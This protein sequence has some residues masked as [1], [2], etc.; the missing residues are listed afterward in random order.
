M[1]LSKSQYMRGLQCSKALWLFKYRPELAAEPDAHRQHLFDTG[2]RV[3][4]LAQQLFPGGVEVAYR[5]GDYP[6]MI[7]E[8]ARSIRQGDVVYEGSFLTD[9][10]FVRA[11]ILVRH[12][13]AWD[14]YEVK[15]TSSTK[16]VHKPDVA[17]QWYVIGRHLPLGRAY[18]VHLNNGYVRD[19]ALDV[20][21]LFTIDEVTEA[22]EDGQAA[23]ER[24]LR[25]LETVL[26]GA[27]P[28][29]PIGTQCNNP[30][31]CDFRAYCW[32]DVPFPSVLDLRK[33][34]GNRKF[35]YYHRGIVTYEDARKHIDLNAV[36]SLQVNTA[37]DRAVHVD[38]GAIGDFLGDV[39]YPV[40][41]LDFETFQ[42]AIPR[43]DGQRP[44]Q[45]VPFQY[46]L[47]VVHE[48][49]ELEHREFLAD[50]NED[51][52]HELARRLLEDL[53]G[54]GTIF[55][56]H[57]QFELDVIRDLAR[58]CAEYDAR[59]LALTRRFKDLEVPFDKLMY[60][61]PDFNG[62]FSIKSVLPALFPG[63]PELDYRN[64][65]IQ[66]GDAAMD[67]FPRLRGIE[68]P[69]EK[70]AIRKALRAYCRL[71]TLAMVKIWEKLKGVIP[72]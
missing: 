47:H 61:H 32:R 27:E 13:E 70:E 9:G 20:Q 34:N 42:D 35:E 16:A 48:T 52:R 50:E 24:N 44:Y 1:Q 6:G 5:P 38:A 71:D 21:G 28:E 46:S 40:S 63:D 30:H 39:R 22:V 23:I 65:A 19:G 57:Q 49:G 29:V 14:L 2:H 62:S 7:D 64:L 37:L 59:L 56:Y 33:L 8:T 68:D 25:R 72:A 3:G 41:F 36:Q 55:A 17:V 10:V 58:H 54:E 53:P 51:P 26:A 18:L 67:I 12:G 66:S 31:E 60:Y 11:D 15:A 43:F 69:A 4:A 45:H